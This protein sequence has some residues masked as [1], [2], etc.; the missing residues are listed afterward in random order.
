VAKFYTELKMKRKSDCVNQ[1][2]FTLIELLAMMVIMGVMASVGVKK[3]DLLS[4]TATIRAIQEGVKELNIRESLT[5]TKINLSPAGWKD[6]AQLFAE[7]DTDL[8]TYYVWSAGPNASGGTLTFRSESI[9]LTRSS[10]TK[11]TSGS[12]QL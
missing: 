4:D 11:S 8:G 7:M 3:L 9:N 1:R 10:S 2:G 5:W 12:W 6:D